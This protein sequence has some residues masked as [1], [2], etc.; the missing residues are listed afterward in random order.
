MERDT[1][2]RLEKKR[3]KK[4]TFL[5]KYFNKT[6]QTMIPGGRKTERF[7]GEKIQVLALYPLSWS[8]Q[9][10]PQET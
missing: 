8:F 3:I 6:E 2:Y 5:E 1:I 4:K 7:Q 10:P 9:I